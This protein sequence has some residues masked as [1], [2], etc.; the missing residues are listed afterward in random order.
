M[1]SVRTTL[2]VSALAIA[3]CPLVA[4]QDAELDADIDVDA[5]AVGE[6]SEPV[7]EV[8][9]GGEDDGGAAV[10]DDT[11]S[12]DDDDTAEEDDPALTPLAHSVPPWWAIGIGALGSLAYL[13]AA[14]VGFIGHDDQARERILAYFRGVGGA[15]WKPITSLLTI[16]AFGAIG[17]GVAM[18]FQLTEHYL[19]PVQAFIIGCTWPAVV[20]NYLSARQQGS[21]KAI[22]RT[23]AQTMRKVETLDAEE[24]MLEQLP[25]SG[26][27]V[28]AAELEELLGRLPA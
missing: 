13:L 24:E 14:F 10:D 15:F 17:G 22:E 25:E 1:S 20:A 26:P 7:D 16:V 8:T 19:V 9:S 3:L 18:V 23:V 5:P 12:A 4:A 27:D 11:G 2:L 21:D 28:D 6:E